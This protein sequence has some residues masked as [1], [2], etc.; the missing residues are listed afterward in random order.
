MILVVIAFTVTPI[1]LV[2]MSVGGFV[3]IFR[4]GY[5][6]ALTTPGSTAYHHL[7]APLLVFE[8][9]GNAFFI[10]FSITLLFLLFTK[11]HRFPGLASWFLALN[12]LFLVA[13]FIAFDFIPAVASQKDPVV[14][15]NMGRAIVAA[16]I[17]IPYF[18]VSKRV[19]NTFVNRKLEPT[20]QPTAEG[21]V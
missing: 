13:D 6:E 3:P 19:K 18:R 5:W 10:L 1:A 12:A 11:D 16:L 20:L 14:L 2:L 8:I 15:R 7:W 9:V 21:G 17:W 4:D